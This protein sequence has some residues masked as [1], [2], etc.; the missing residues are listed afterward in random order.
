MRNQ[1]Q[2]FPGNRRFKGGARNTQTI[3]LSGLAPTVTFDDLIE[4]F[5]MFKDKPLVKMHYNHKGV[6]IGTAEI[7]FNDKISAQKV[8][9]TY[10]GVPL[11]KYKMSLTL[12]N[13]IPL[14][15]FILVSDRNKMDPNFTVK[16]KI[17]AKKS[18]TKM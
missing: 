11:D 10:D 16:V 17:M 1:H 2:T 4:L 3:L 7:T 14:K 12:V 18:L 8:I 15:P 5:S 6:M 13:V 9:Q